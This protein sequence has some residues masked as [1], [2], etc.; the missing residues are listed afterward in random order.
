[1]NHVFVGGKNFNSQRVLDYLHKKVDP[2]L[3]TIVI[4]H[5]IGL[6]KFVGE[7]AGGLSLRRTVLRPEL[8]GRAARSCEV[9]DLYLEAL[10]GVLVLG[11][12][13]RAEIV[14]DLQ[15]RTK[16]AW[17]VWLVELED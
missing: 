5:G 1:M 14:R 13:H 11:A 15:K 4:G 2:D 6:E 12:G 8:Y 3:D 7:A 9:T 17:P 10:G 16:A